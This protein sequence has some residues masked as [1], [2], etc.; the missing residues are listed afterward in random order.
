M[1]P[2]LNKNT[3]KEIMIF[4]NR[5]APANVQCDESVQ[6]T[7]RHFTEQKATPSDDEG[8]KTNTKAPIFKVGIFSHL[9]YWWLL[10]LYW[11]GHKRKIRKEDVYN[12]PKNVTCK[13]LGLR[14]ERSWTNELLEA[15]AGIKICPRLLC[16]L[17]KAFGPSFVVLILGRLVTDMCLIGQAL[18]LEQIVRT[19]KGYPGLV[20]GISICICS[21]LYLLLHQGWTT[22]AV[23]TGLQIRGACSCLIYR[24]IM[25][26]NLAVVQKAEVE[27]LLT[28][29]TKDLKLFELLAVYCPYILEGP[30]IALIVSCILWDH[31]GASCLVGMALLLL[32]VP[33]QVFTGKKISKLTMVA[34]PHTEKRL[35][36][37]KE[38]ADG[39]V[40]IKQSAWEELFE[41]R[42]Q[43]TRH[44][45]ASMLRKATFFH[46]L[47]AMAHSQGTN[48]MT[49]LS[50]STFVML[51]NGYTVN[52]AF[53]TLCAIQA[54]RIPLC[55]YFPLGVSVIIKVVATVD[56]IQ[57][58]LL[59]DEYSGDN[60]RRLHREGPLYSRLILMD[61]SAKWDPYSTQC[62]LTHLNMG[63]QQ[64]ELL[65]IIGPEGGGKSS[66]LH[67]LM[68]EL[69]PCSGK[70]TVNGHCVYC[71]QKPWIF[72]A[73]LRKNITCGRPY[74][75]E[76]FKKVIEI[77][78]LEED[79]HHFPDRDLTSVGDGGDITLSPTQRAKVNLA[80]AVYQEAD[81][82]LLDN[83]LASMNLMTATII[84]NKC[85]LEFLKA[86]TVIMV[87]D[88]PRFL[89][90]ADQILILK[91]GKMEGCGSYNDLKKHGIELHRFVEYDKH[92]ELD[93]DD[94]EDE[95][96]PDVNS[97]NDGSK[98]TLLVP[99]P[100][101]TDLYS[102]CRKGS[103][104]PR[105]SSLKTS[106]LDLQT[107]IGL[108][109]DRHT[110]PSPRLLQ[111]YITAGRS[112]WILIL[113]AAGI[114]VT[115]LL[116]FFWDYLYLIWTMNIDKNTYFTNEWLPAV[117]A[118]KHYYLV[119]L[120]CQ[121]GLMLIF[122]SL[123]LL[124]LLYVFTKA[125][126][127]LHDNLFGA[128]LHAPLRL[129][130]TITLERIL[131]AFSHDMKVLDEL[132]PSTLLEL[133]QYMVM[134][135]GC[136]MVIGV[137]CQWLIIPTIVL[138]L[139]SYLVGTLCLPSTRALKKIEDTMMISVD[140]LFKSTLEGITVIRSLNAEEFFAEEYAACYDS[141][142]SA[143]YLLDCATHALGLWIGLFS[144][145]YTAC[146]TLGYRMISPEVKPAYLGL[147]THC[148]LLMSSLV[149]E[150]VAYSAYAA[151]QLV[152]VGRMVELGSLEQEDLDL[153]PHS[154]DAPP[155]LPPSEWPAKGDIRATHLSLQYSQD[156]PCVLQN[157]NFT[158]KSAEKVGVVGCV[159]A[160]KSGLLSAL[161]RIAEPQS[162]EAVWID[163]IA[164]SNVP[165]RLL[166]SKISV[167]PR[168]PILFSGKLR[169]N[170]DPE[171]AL[172][173]NIL[174]DALDKVKLC[175]AVQALPFGLQ[176]E[177]FDWDKVFTIHQR[178][179]LCLARALIDGNH[180]LFIDMVMGN[181]DPQMELGMLQI[182]RKHFSEW[183]VIIVSHRLRSVMKT[184][185]VL[186]LES[187]KMAEYGHPYLLLQNEYSHFYKMVH[188]TRRA[189]KK[190]LIDLAREAY[191]G[192][193]PREESE[194]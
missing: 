175:R 89:Y 153:L 132:L 144:I 91:D 90:K 185:R 120:W 75:E 190:E 183:T 93:H 32:L 95:D 85:I 180:I 25:K 5:V 105:S 114:T 35:R 42:L 131:N 150:I 163:D 148:S 98:A 15:V 135:L 73:T 138:I 46:V 134:I 6:A 26:L 118:E 86:K 88:R 162:T 169:L 101:P 30:I 74:Q 72:P 160:G 49:L 56:K 166:R 87:V 31:L 96:S 158:I 2:C 130:D 27:D 156:K 14:L 164:I 34:G 109:G 116:K 165:L 94:E 45:E 142:S 54:L 177:S 97:V 146:I 174:W 121:I 64:G 127:N 83:P 58:I 76:R 167:V 170:L 192:S 18:L 71:P 33:L 123:I 147:T 187:G 61:T 194:K 1:D 51:G 178:Q 63:V 79:S 67:L 122:G 21:S 43:H 36:F 68:G 124:A 193:L 80:R 38:I 189:V 104:E 110:A 62:T 70:V 191:L 103:S 102:Y 171:N 9:F 44:K 57:K 7:P 176:T 99:Q 23:T 136:M 111:R 159:G 151:M 173:D 19:P 119:A 17:C 52:K 100:D 161:L 137:I 126:T 10:P 59:L 172:T 60:D 143:L 145:L 139:C 50:I 22:M 112:G 154:E 107:T 184:D 125:S 37:V 28:S 20:Y 11:K 66:L 82:Y 115:L 152:S 92:G 117:N 149:P 140:S 113:I 77:C 155:T 78:G 3:V 157:L 29:V 133:T 81:I 16:A 48:V 168:F 129:L 55:L 186:V 65:E 40:Q 128:M 12:V 8:K 41:K 108:I 39:I 84:F 69:P 181:L 182:I 53:L 47:I 141:H 106:S 179:L 24:K 188:Q 4:N 13:L